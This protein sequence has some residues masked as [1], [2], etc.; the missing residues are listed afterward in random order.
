[1]GA[2][3]AGESAVSLITAMGAHKF[4]WFVFHG[5]ISL[6]IFVFAW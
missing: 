1:L 5:Y 6:A 2:Y 3:I 4:L